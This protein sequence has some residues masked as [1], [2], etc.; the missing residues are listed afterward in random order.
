MAAAENVV[1]YARNSGQR[2]DCLRSLGEIARLRR[3]P[4]VAGM[5]YLVQP[6]YQTE[7]RD[8]SGDCSQN[9]LAGR[10]EHVVPE[11]LGRTNTATPA[12]ITA[13][14][15]NSAR[16]IGMSGMCFYFSKFSGVFASVTSP[17]SIAFR[18]RSRCASVYW[19]SCST[20]HA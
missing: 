2:P 17:D 7:R 15:G 10:T 5:M 18:V 16:S 19:K 9:A 12:A 3:A 13:Y 14:H 20:R 11:P 8:A 1:E 4:N 6:H